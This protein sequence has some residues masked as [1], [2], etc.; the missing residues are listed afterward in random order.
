M[1]EADLLDVLSNGSNP[2]K[3]L[4]HVPKVYLASKTFELDDPP[5]G[6]RPSAL[7]WVSG[8]GSET[9]NFDPPVL[10]EGKVEMYFQTV[11]DAMKESLF[12]V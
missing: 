11:L 3:I 4:V 5:P 7:R 1:S 8:V 12:K 2:T 6:T 10:L 9:V